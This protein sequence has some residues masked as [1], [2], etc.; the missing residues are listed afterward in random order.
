MIGQMFEQLKI[1]SILK[2]NKDGLQ[3]FDD[4]LCFFRTKK[5]STSK[6]VC[7][8]FQLS[9]T[10]AKLQIEALF[11]FWVNSQETDLS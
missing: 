1:N 8:T 4:F 7:P 9:K 5:R 11:L 10:F 6:N 3:Y 2:Y